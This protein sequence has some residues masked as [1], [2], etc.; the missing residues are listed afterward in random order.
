MHEKNRTFDPQTP[1]KYRRLC[2]HER[3]IWDRYLKT[4]KHKYTKIIYDLPITTEPLSDDIL[5]DNYLEAYKH[6]TNKRI[7][8]LAFATDHID[9]FEI[10]PR[11]N[12]QALGQ[13]LSYSFI[14]KLQFS[15]VLPIN[16]IVL[17]DYCT[18]IDTVCFDHFDVQ[19][20]CLNQPDHLI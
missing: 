16:K 18:K 9:L 8:V 4:I 5:T 10:K 14:Y 1:H 6:L 20:I 2:Q 19:I 7:D 15:P 3:M 13:V 17:C 12:S 11:A